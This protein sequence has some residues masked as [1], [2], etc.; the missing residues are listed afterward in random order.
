MKERF[1]IYLTFNP[2]PFNLLLSMVGVTIND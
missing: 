1:P 2:Y